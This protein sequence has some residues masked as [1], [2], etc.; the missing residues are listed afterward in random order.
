MPEMTLHWSPKSPFVRKVMIAAHELGLTDRIVLKRSVAAM[1]SVNPAIMADNP[2]GKIPTLVLED[3]TAIMDS[4]VI[5]DYFDGLVGGGRLFPVEPKARTTA[6]TRHALGTGL[7]DLLILWRN[8][9]DKP[10]E[11]QTPEWLDAFAQKTT[12]TLDLLE[13]IAPALEDK[14]FGIAHLTFGSALGYMDFRFSDIAWREGRPALASWFATFQARPSA[15]AT[16]VA[17]G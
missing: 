17:D 13:A 6:L 7:L 4:L 12:A 11:R 9:R 10:V 8:E 15:I 3:G 5:C 14:P 1:K 16:E 2:L